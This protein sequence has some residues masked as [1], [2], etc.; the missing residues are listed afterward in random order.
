MEVGDKLE[1]LSGLRN[2]AHVQWNDQ[3]LPTEIPPKNTLILVLWKLNT[4]YF[5]TLL[6]IS[7]LMLLEGKTV[8]LFLNTQVCNH[9]DVLLGISP[10]SNHVL[11][12]SE[13][14]GT[15]IHLCYWWSALPRGLEKTVSDWWIW[16]WT[17]HE[18]VCL[19]FTYWSSLHASSWNSW[20]SKLLY[21][22]LMSDTIMEVGLVEEI[23]V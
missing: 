20:Q 18:W 17:H 16:I 10:Y 22:N 3:I 21:Q 2:P 23:L 15:C 4:V 5:R 7:S 8:G 14:S 1:L 13:I 9:C 19:Y 6:W 12:T 11:Y